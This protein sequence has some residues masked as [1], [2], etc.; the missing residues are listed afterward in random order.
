VK[1]IVSLL[2]LAPT[3]ADSLGIAVPA[4]TFRGHS[5]LRGAPGARV[6]TRNTEAPPTYAVTEGR[7]RLI[8]QTEDGA[9]ELF[10][11]VADAGETQDLAGAQP[12]WAAAHRQA[13]QWFLM[14]LRPESPAPMAPLGPSELEA[15]RALG[16]VN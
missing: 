11:A 16:Y 10:D 5:L 3:I 6:V 7:Y 2:D 8:F 4:G 1:E 14:T 15:L 12:S 13:L 9:H